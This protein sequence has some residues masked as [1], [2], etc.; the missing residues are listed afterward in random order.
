VPGISRAKPADP[1]ED[2]IDPFAHVQGFVMHD[3]PTSLA[4]SD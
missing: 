2:R 1:G 3:H 4:R